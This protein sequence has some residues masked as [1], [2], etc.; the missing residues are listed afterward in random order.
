MLQLVLHGSKYCVCG[1]V[2]CRDRDG[3]GE[4]DGDAVCLR[5]PMNL[6]CITDVALADFAK[7]YIKECQVSKT[8]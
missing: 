2:T 1:N 6:Y 3:S 7:G 8:L 5:S 4:Y